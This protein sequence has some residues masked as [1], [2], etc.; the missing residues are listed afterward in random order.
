MSAQLAEPRSHG[1][2]AELTACFFFGH[3]DPGRTVCRQ[4]EAGGSPSRADPRLLLGKGKQP[5]IS[6]KFMRLLDR[7]PEESSGRAVP[8]L[9]TVSSLKA[10]KAASLR[11]VQPGL[12]RIQAAPLEEAQEF[13]FARGE[14][15]QRKDSSATA[16]SDCRPASRKTPAVQP[17][18]DQ[19]HRSAA[20]SI[21]E[22]SP[23]SL[24]PAAAAKRSFVASSSLQ[25]AS[26]SRPVA[27]PS[28]FSAVQNI[29]NA[30]QQRAGSRRRALGSLSLSCLKRDCV[31]SPQ[32]NRGTSL[33]LA[34]DPGC[35]L[36][37]MDAIA[38]NQRPWMGLGRQPEMRRAAGPPLPVQRAS[39][40]ER[41]DQLTFKYYSRIASN[42][43]TRRTASPCRSAEL[44]PQT[45]D[46]CL[47]EPALPALRLE[48][49]PR[50]SW[51]QPA[52]HR[53]RARVNAHQS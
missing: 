42:T 47:T 21:L 23:F 53:K 25:A 44:Q 17:R 31:D 38:S 10:L 22:F 30:Y 18:V 5:L 40:K 27:F 49:L 52:L 33:L 45:G 6:H 36:T 20:L 9:P 32:A 46:S 15:E 37:P 28:E 29:I 26:Q 11:D 3:Q 24:L 14:P 50:S 35:E 4:E 1:R 19:L 13:S 2:P 7:L 34:H 12:Q 16:E 41:I 43:H 48:L 51:Q 8:L 39:K